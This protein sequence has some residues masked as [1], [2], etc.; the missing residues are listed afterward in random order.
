[1]KTNKNR[2]TKNSTRKKL[3]LFFNCL[4]CQMMYYQKVSITKCGRAFSSLYIQQSK[5]LS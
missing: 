1:M 3:M 2:Y 4:N 5:I